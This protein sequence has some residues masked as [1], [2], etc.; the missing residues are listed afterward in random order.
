MKRQC[1]SRPQR[2][3]P[4]ELWLMEK[5]CVLIDVNQ[6]N[7]TNNHLLLIFSQDRA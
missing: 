5:I 3:I 6:C 4:D 2:N 1:V 7:F